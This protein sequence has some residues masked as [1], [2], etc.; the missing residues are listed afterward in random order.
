MILNNIAHQRYI[1]GKIE[2]KDIVPFIVNNIG[3][4]KKTLRNFNSILKYITLIKI[5]Y[6]NTL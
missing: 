2:Y 4:K 5:N 1:D 6:E 3:N